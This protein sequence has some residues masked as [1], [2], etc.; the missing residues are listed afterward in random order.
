MAALLDAIEVEQV[1]VHGIS[2]GGPAAIQFAARH[3]DRICYLISS[4]LYEFHTRIALATSPIL[5]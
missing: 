2:A 5:G 3:P 1:A 4:G